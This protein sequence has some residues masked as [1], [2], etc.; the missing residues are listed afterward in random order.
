M[1]D[2]TRI[3]RSGDQVQRDYYQANKEK[4][5][6]RRKAK[7]QVL[8][9]GTIAVPQDLEAFLPAFPPLARERVRCLLRDE[10]TALQAGDLLQ[11]RGIRQS[12]RIQA[13][14]HL[15][16]AVLEMVV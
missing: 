1:L 2:I 10:A 16:D 3:P 14:L 7:G 9:P 4:W 5:S 6:T 13:V 11:A 12:L 8:M 15:P